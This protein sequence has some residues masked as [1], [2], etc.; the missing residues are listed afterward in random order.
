MAYAHPGESLEEALRFVTSCD[1]A[2]L[3]DWRG[4]VA[5]E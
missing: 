2:C 5:P 3:P 1:A 4:P